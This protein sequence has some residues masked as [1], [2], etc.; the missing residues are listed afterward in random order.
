MPS[1]WEALVGFVLLSVTVAWVLGLYP[2]L[3]RRRALAVRL[4]LLRRADPDLRLLESSA[5]AT[6]LDSLAA[7]VV[8]ARLDFA[9]CPETYYFQEDEDR[10]SLAAMVGHRLTAGVLSAA[11]DDLAGTLDQ[12]HLR[13]GGERRSVFAAYAADHRQAGGDEEANG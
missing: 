7:E 8:H 1:C 5:G 12:R 3:A 4:S 11:L 2:A 6:T 9:Q 13:I 10:M